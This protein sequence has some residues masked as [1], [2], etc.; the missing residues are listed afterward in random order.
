MLFLRRLFSFQQTDF[1]DVLC[2]LRVPCVIGIRLMSGEK[3]VVRVV[4]VHPD[5]FK[6][7]FRVNSS[8]QVFR[9]ELETINPD[10]VVSY[11]VIKDA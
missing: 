6:G 3:R 2:H 11:W 8:T 7:Y 4:E 5:Y 9:Q 1:G 10:V